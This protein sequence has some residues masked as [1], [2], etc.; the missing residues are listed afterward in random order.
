MANN[1]I[2][3][4][5]QPRLPDNWNEQER[6]FY[7]RVVE[8]FDDIYSR[9]RNVTMTQ[10]VKQVLDSSVRESSSA[11]TFA[12]Y[13]LAATFAKM[14]QLSAKVG[15]FDFETVQNLVSSALAVEQLSGGDV[16][17]NNLYVRYAQIGKAVIESVCV[18]CSED[19]KYYTLTF[20]ADG[21]T[22]A[23]ETEVTQ[24]EI[25]DGWTH[26]AQR[27]VALEI[28]AA[29]MNTGSLKASEAIVDSITA[30]RIDVAQLFA[31]EIFADL[32][33]TSRI[34][35]GK[36][37][38]MIADES[39][40]TSNLLNNVMQV[41]QEGAHLRSAAIVDGE[42]QVDR[43]ATSVN[44]SSRGMRIRDPLHKRADGTPVS[45]DDLDRWIATADKQAINNTVI[46]DSANCSNI[47]RRKPGEVFD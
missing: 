43:N 20:N 22:T 19:G 35:G 27:I 42:V 30:G 1:S 9:F 39:A 34:F 25:D 7:N 44:L 31:S 45:G 5:E 36:S 17:I 15:T 24:Q 18:K 4:Y 13:S 23:T 3:Q 2:F 28:T 26:N 37:I 41:D 38:T 14:T 32:L 47:R 10:V 29:E 11:T 12:A 16:S 33:R 6:R 40:S 46:Y 8:I 21:T